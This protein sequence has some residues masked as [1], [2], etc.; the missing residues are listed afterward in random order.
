MPLRNLLIIS[1]AAIISVACYSVSARNRYA[2][3]FAEALNVV[4]QR[5][6]Q[7][8]TR[9]ALFDAAMDGLV[10]RLDRHSRYL[11]DDD[12]DNFQISIDQQF[13]GIGV[14]VG[15][16]GAPER[17]FVRAA[18]PGSPADRAGLKSGDI[19]LAIDGV[20][21][22]DEKPGDAVKQMKGNVGEPVKLTVSRKGKSLD[23]EMVREVI[24][25]PS[26]RG[27]RWLPDGTWNFTVEDDPKIGYL[28][29]DSFGKETTGEFRAALERLEGRIDGLIIDLRGNSGGL[30]DCAIDL[31]DMLL[32]IELDIVSIRTR[33][34]EIKQKTYSSRDAPVLDLSIPIVV[35]IDR[36]SASAS[37]IMSGCLQD[38]DRAKLIGEQ[39]W[40][41]GTVQDVLP[42]EHGES[43]LKL[44]TSSYWRPSGK[45]I[46]RDFAKADGDVL[47]GVQ[48]DEG[49]K[50]SQT[51][52]GVQ[53][54]EYYR[55]E[56]ELRVLTG[57]MKFP[58]V[59]SKPDD[60]AEE[61]LATDS[62]LAEPEPDNTVKDDPEVT[63]DDAEAKEDAPAL[64]MIDPENY[65]D[66]PFDRAVEYLQSIRAKSQSQTQPA[67]A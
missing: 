44:T 48:P 56:H 11:H 62:D 28:R 16:E 6:L 31:C 59:F 40:G 2:N 65:R 19:I 15:R 20:D 41:K 39:T 45:N 27:D 1:I 14:F 38:H 4:E 46:D 63:Q 47:W 29:I 5:A 52:I 54:N 18:F 3:I 66:Q 36:Y 61:A 35:L 17:L 7:S 51:E 21:L 22:N 64:D 53:R 10:S 23:V 26:I 34:R 57:G 9:E 58:K 37:E 55:S 43:A 67:A 13:G 12:L 33:R 30:L 25:V 60:E 49:Y 32:P 24:D 50:I 8:M 42:I